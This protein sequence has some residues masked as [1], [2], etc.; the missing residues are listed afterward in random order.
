MS[1]VR[2]GSVSR[3][4]RLHADRA[5]H[6]RG[7]HRHPGRD[8]RPAL[9]Q[10]A[11]ARP[12]RQGP[13]RHPR[14]RVGRR[15]S[16][17]RTAVVCRTTARPRPPA[18][19][20]A[21]ERRA[22]RPCCSRSRRTHRTRSAG[23]SSTTRPRCPPAGRAR[24]PRTSTPAPRPGRSPSAAAATAPPPTPTAAPPVRD[25]IQGQ[26]PGGRKD[27]GRLRRIRLLDRRPRRCAILTPWPISP[28]AWPTSTGARSN[29]RCGSGATPRRRPCSPPT[30]ARSLIAHVRRRRALPQPRRHGALP[31]RRR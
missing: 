4:A 16:T 6:R 18:R 30:S 28:P 7:D 27:P 5:A 13:G 23:R 15:A 29:A 3:P 14:H 20:P 21:P 17:R 8:R 2:H 12:H 31:L 1:T 25:L 11:G 26:W 19:R 22:A 24:A 10:R 9:R